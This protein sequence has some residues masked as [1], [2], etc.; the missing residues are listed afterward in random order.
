MVSIKVYK[1]KK[2]NDSN[3]D[4]VK[5][6]KSQNLAKFKFGHLFKSKNSIK[7][8]STDTMEEYHFFNL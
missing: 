4:K 3:F 7:V 2:S 8:K 1:R 5:K 6:S